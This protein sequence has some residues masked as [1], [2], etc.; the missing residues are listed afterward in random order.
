MLINLFQEVPN[1]F[2]EAMNS[3]ESEQWHA[4][5]EEEYEGLI[6]IGIWKLI[7]ATIGT[8]PNITFAAMRLSQFNNNPLDLHIKHAKH[9]LRYLKAQ[10]NF[11]SSMTDVQMVD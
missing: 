8:R 7:Y 11:I 1:T 6:V 3:L 5:A 4:A 2:Q 10:R 9:I